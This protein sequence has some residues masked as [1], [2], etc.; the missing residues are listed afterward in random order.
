MD[1]VEL[2]AHSTTMLKIKFAFLQ[3]IKQSSYIYY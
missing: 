2:N 1:R 3:L